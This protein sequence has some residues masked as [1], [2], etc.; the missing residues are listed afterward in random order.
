MLSVGAIHFALATKMGW[1]EM[2]GG[3]V[4]MATALGCRALGSC[5]GR[6]WG[7]CT[8]QLPWLAEESPDHM[9]LQAGY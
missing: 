3:A 2:G 6:E 4:H 9:A 8:G 7:L 1:G 5:L